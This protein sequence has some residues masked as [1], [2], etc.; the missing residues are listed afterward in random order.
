M[1]R[2]DRRSRPPALALSR[3]PCF[4]HRATRVRWTLLLGLAAATAPTRPAGLAAQPS[5][6]AHAPAA[7]ARI[8]ALV[9]SGDSAWAQGARDEA[10]RHYTAALRRDRDAATRSAPPYVLLRLATLAVERNAL[11]EAE[12]LYR[13]YVA[14]APEDADGHVALA[15]TLAWQGRTADA[16]AV[17]DRVLVGTPRAR[18]AALGR[19]QAL[20]WADRHGEALAAYDAWLAHAP[21]DAEAARARAQVL[22]WAG[23]LV[24]A[25]D[26]YRDRL[27][28]GADPEAARGLA[29]VIAWSG[30]LAGSAAAWRAVLAR[31]SADVDA[32]FGLAE[33]LH[34]DGRTDEAAR[35]LERARALAPDRADVR[36]LRDVVQAER[37]T[38]AEPVL[39][40]SQDSDGNVVASLTLTMAPRAWRGVRWRVAGGYRDA[41][42]PTQSAS[43]TNG[44]LQAAWSTPGRRLVLSGEAGATRLSRREREPTSTP[45]RDVTRPWVVAR[46]SGQPTERVEAGLTLAAVPF[47]ETAALI[48]RG[49]HTRALDADVTV[50][51]P[52][53]LAL[54]VAGGHLQVLGG[55]VANGR[56]ALVSSLRWTPADA[57]GEGAGRGARGGALAGRTSLA[58]TWRQVA[59][60]TL[61][62]PD[63][64][65]APHRFGL[66]ELGVRHTRGRELG[67][68]LSLDGG[69]GTQQIRFTPDA[70]ARGTVALRGAVTVQY[71][72]RTGYAIE[73]V[74]GATS[75]ASAVA[76][77]DSEYR[78][79]WLSLRGRAPIF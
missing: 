12:A 31:D 13:D 53:R 5:Q 42:D 40:R 43:A 21:E 62:R 37:R 44:R 16:V 71:A 52:G 2:V 24:E 69:V 55:T 28:R 61:G 8:A 77:G 74:G 67:W 47:D 4:R 73:L 33:T 59:W 15:R 58:A 34:W 23:R 72:P 65:F 32:W 9:A 57:G 14:R 36:T 51:L 30:D 66:L 1:S 79:H 46:A 22:A 25:A 48:T 11:P 10:A 64:Y 60:D 76:R 20:A 27:A 50:T 35:A 63:G 6:L 75:V 18:D 49:V 70:D 3:V 45:R 39:L 41:A 19:A 7:D 29:R 38:T 17:Y 26:A 78:L 54:A 56:R 68:R